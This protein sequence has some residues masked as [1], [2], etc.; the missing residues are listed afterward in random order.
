MFRILH[1]KC[2]LPARH[3]ASNNTKLTSKMVI[4]R[5]CCTFC[6]ALTDTLI[7]LV[8]ATCC[9]LI[10]ATLLPAVQP[11]AFEHDGALY[12]HSNFD[13]EISGAAPGYKG[14]AGFGVAPGVLS[15][16]YQ[17][18][19]GFDY[20]REFSPKLSQIYS[21]YLNRP[22][23]DDSDLCEGHVGGGGDDWLGGESAHD[24]T[25]EQD[26]FDSAFLKAGRKIEEYERSNQEYLATDP[27]GLNFSAYVYVATLHAKYNELVTKQIKLK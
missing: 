16:D 22:T 15:H 13:N 21:R 27:R 17:D 24:V 2:T 25:V 19:H 3:P 23:G 12:L 6:A 20:R 10:S 14:G 4:A 5:P 7:V 9:G 8:W 26:E 18:P 11:V 1:L